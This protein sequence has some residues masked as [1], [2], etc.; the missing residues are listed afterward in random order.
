MGTPEILHVGSLL[1]TQIDGTADAMARSGVAAVEVGFPLDPLTG[2]SMLG[3]AVAVDRAL[4][5]AGIA[6]RVVHP[7]LGAER[8]LSSPDDALRESTIAH[9]REMIEACGLFGARLMVVHAGGFYALGDDVEAAK[10][11]A[12]SVGRFVHEAASTGVTLVVE[13]L[14]SGYVLESAGAVRSFVEGF[15][16]PTVR[17]CYDSGHAN[18]TE[19]PAGAVEVLAPVLA[20]LHLHDN[21]GTADQHQMPGEGS[22]DWRAV[23]DALRAAGYVGPALLELPLADGH[24]AASMGARALGLMGY[25]TV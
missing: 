4:R 14:P 16:T 6:V 15:G 25:P 17:A 7:A 2:D 20:H 1:G 23:G 10:R 11:A 21:D 18:I 19:D 22:I 9:Y 12:D 3:R 8:D 13:N 24:T 5:A